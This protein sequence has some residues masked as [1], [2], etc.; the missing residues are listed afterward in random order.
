VNA[1]TYIARSRDADVLTTL[2]QQ[3]SRLFGGLIGDEVSRSG[4]CSG[5]VSAM[6]VI[7]TPESVLAT[8]E[9]PGIDPSTIE[10]SVSGDYLELR[11]EKPDEQLPEKTSWHSFERTVGSFRRTLYLPMPVDTDGIEAV[12]NHGL[13][14]IK[15]PKRP[16]VLP[17]KIS[18]QAKG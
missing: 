8:A 7:E 15:L 16:E 17:K 3:V 2:Q 5:W 12:E 18:I 10:V 1:R 14:T 13:L 4:R 11:G 9:I 6:D